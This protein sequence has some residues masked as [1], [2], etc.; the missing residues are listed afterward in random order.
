MSEDN[1]YS[2]EQL[3]NLLTDIKRY[4]IFIIG[5]LVGMSSKLFGFF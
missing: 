3:H 5:L 4:I 2:N 1:N